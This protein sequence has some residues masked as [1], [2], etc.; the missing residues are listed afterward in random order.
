M[1]ATFTVT[2]ILAF[3]GLYAATSGTPTNADL[4]KRL[5]ACGSIP[6]GASLTVV[7]TTR[8]FIN[9]PKD[10]YPNLKLSVALHGATA[11]SVSNGGADGYALGAQ[12]KPDCWSYYLDLELSA[13][14][15]TQTGRVDIGSESGFRAIPDYL[16]HFKVASKPPDATKRL[17]GNGDVHGIVLLGPACPVEHIP[18]DPA[19]APKPYRT[20]IDIWSLFTGSHYK[21]VSNDTS[22][23]FDVSLEPGTYGL[24]VVH[25]AV[26]AI[27]PRCTEVSISVTAKKSQNVTVNCDTG[28][29]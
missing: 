9:L 15:K 27:Y 24:A 4:K 20:T 12:E 3:S 18:P 1:I 17:P 22:G 29:R 13:K 16:I 25:S 5:T 2:F 6:N 8:V 23:V 19:C 21:S 28:I 11:G 26:G 10:Y 7:Q 14:N